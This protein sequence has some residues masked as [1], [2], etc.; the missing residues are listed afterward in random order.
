MAKRW[1]STLKRL[2]AEAPQDLVS[3]LKQGA[4]FSRELSPHL[5][6]KNIDADLLYRV[7][8]KRRHCIFHIEFQKVSNSTMPGRLWEVQHTGITQI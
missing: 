8:Y 4:Q 1:D 3:W 6:N 7:R 2:M 5:G